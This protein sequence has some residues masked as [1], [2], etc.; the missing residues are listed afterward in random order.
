M[1]KFP[2]WNTTDQE[3][4]DLGLIFL[5]RGKYQWIFFLEYLILLDTKQINTF[6]RYK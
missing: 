1:N 6:V 5:T 3:M 2:F 4:L